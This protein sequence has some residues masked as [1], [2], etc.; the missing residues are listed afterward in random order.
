MNFV[1]KIVPPLFW[2]LKYGTNGNELPSD[3]I[4]VKECINILIGFYFY[5]WFRVV[6]LHI[7]HKHSYK[8]VIR[9]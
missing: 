3:F 2:E 5:G 7:S 1:S 4:H 8:Q 9:F 6:T